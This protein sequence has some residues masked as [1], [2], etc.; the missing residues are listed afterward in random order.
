MHEQ[1]VRQ[2]SRPQQ[3]KPCLVLEHQDTQEVCRGV[4]DGRQP[5]SHRAASVLREDFVPP[6][7]QEM[8]EHQ[9]P[10]A[11]WVIEPQ[12]LNICKDADGDDILLG[13][14]GFG[15]VRGFSS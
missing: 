5:L 7:L 3:A 6:S 2:V 15:S 9:A 10:A 13:K 11:D 14:G 4:L 8:I 12:D 1:A